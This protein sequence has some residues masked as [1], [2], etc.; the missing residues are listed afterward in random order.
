LEFELWTV[1]PPL[2][3]FGASFARH[4]VHDLHR[5]HYF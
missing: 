3:D 1:K 4:G 5:A 2:R